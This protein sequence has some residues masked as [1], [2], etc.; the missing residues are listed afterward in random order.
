MCG[1]DKQHLQAYRFNL[2]FDRRADVALD[3]LQ[4]GNYLRTSDPRSIRHGQEYGNLCG[5]LK[6]LLARIAP[7]GQDS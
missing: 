3:S 7:I 1:H 6:P 5:T 2:A 4:G